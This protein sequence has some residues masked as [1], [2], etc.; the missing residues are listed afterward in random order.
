MQINIQPKHDL[1]QETISLLTNQTFS[2]TYT[3]V[4]DQPTDKGDYKG[5]IN[6][7]ILVTKFKSGKY[8]LYKEG[9]HSYYN[10][11]PKLLR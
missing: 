11:P 4:L 5:D 1:L 3:A 9:D 6:Q 2:K 7:L 10:I 8:Y